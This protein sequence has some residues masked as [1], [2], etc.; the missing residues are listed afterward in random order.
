MAKIHYGIEKGIAQIILD[1]GKVNAMDFDFFEELADTLD[2]VGE[3]GAKA[4]IIT[5]RPGYFS[6]GLDVKLMPTL[7]PTEL[8][9]LAEN[10]ARNLL[11]VY[12]LPIPTVAVCSGHAIAGG[13]MLCFTCDLRFVIDGPYIIQMNEILAGIPFPSWMLFIGRSAIPVRWQVETF[14][15]ARAYSPADAVEKEVF[16]G[17]IKDGEDPL[18]YAR[19]QVEKLNSLNLMAYETSKKRL[20]DGDVRQVLELLKNELPFREADIT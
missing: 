6:G 14:L 4:L 1:D 13:A 5:G 2:H 19:A 18:A 7:S 9:R 16:H 20:R 17:L 8:N 3:D 11:K 15:H 12:S 10:L